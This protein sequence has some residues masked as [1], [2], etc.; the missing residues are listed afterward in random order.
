MKIDANQFE[1]ALMNLAVNARDAMPTGGTLTISGHDEIVDA[2]NPVTKDL[3]CG[4]YVRI[5]I[6]DTGVG[7]NEATLAKAMEPFFTTKGVGKG[8]GLGLSMVQG[9][10]AQS[11]GAMQ[12]SS[13]IGKGTVVS[14][15]LPRAE[16]ED[17]RQL[18]EQ[19]PKLSVEN[20]RRGSRILLVDDDSLVSMNTAYMLMDL[21]HSVL[22]L[23]SGADA[24][25][26]LEMDAQFDVVITD[27][28]MPGM[29]GLDLATKI[30]QIQPKMPIIIA[31]GY[32]ELPRH[33]TLGFPRLNKPYS[34]QELA[35]A[36][37]QVSRANM[38]GIDPSVFCQFAGKPVCRENEPIAA[39]TQ[40]ILPHPPRTLT[41]EIIC[42]SDS[43][44]ERKRQFHETSWQP[45]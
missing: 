33:L 1:L 27:Y 44:A 11:G 35:E 17:V 10:I 32:A 15:W 16:R 23:P 30:R 25:R 37:E 31:S 13:Q 22:E 43:Q 3:P 5:S 6:A 40:R 21:G 20:G 38:S 7:M 39:K 9:L 19:P 34:Q 14:L 8:T 41:G 18:P 2:Q 12:I 29:T 36:I 42:P 24:V 28:A 26:Q 4:N 45:S